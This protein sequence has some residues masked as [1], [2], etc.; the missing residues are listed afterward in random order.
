MAP[1]RGQSEQPRGVAAQDRRLVVV[2]E[3]VGREHRVHRVLLPGDGVVGAEHDLAGADLRHQ[4]A[5]RLGREHQRVVIHLVEILGR[6][7]LEDHA[8]VA[9]LWRDEAG[10]VRPRR[11]GREIAAP[12]RREHL[13]PGIARRACPRRSGAG[14]RWWFPGD[15]RPGSPANRCRRT[16]GQLRRA[17]RVDEQHRPQLLR[18]RQHGW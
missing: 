7:L 11:V 12:V 10:V 1:S 4:V 9:V 14:A 2:A 18:L 8:W 3:R 13:Q 17:L 5:Q 6:L 16:L 15:S